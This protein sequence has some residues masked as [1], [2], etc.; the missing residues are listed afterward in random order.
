MPYICGIWNVEWWEIH[1]KK[2]VEIHI[3]KV[4]KANT[5]IIFIPIHAHCPY[6]ILNGAPVLRKIIF[7]K[8]QPPWLIH[9]FYNV[10]AFNGFIVNQELDVIPLLIYCEIDKCSKIKYP[11][12][13]MC[14]TPF[15]MTD[16]SSK[17]YCG[18]KQCSH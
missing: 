18:S 16:C 5:C 15:N 14:M 13:Y 11:S 1:F 8:N 9:L 4:T 2:L 12:T 17:G 7:T 10:T 6:L 3:L